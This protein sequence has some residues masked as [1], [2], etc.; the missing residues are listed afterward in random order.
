MSLGFSIYTYIYLFHTLFKNVYK[1][2]RQ[3]LCKALKNPSWKRMLTHCV[4][5]STFNRD[6]V[7][8]VVESVGFIA[9]PRSCNLVLKMD[10]QLCLI[11]DSDAHTRK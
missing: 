9:I 10:E 5:L 3:N 6:T 7:V 4:W 2:V 11:P 8:V 1:S